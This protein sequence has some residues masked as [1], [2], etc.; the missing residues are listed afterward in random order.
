[1]TSQ[2]DLET[3]QQRVVRVFVS[4]TFRDMHAEREELVKRIFP[5]LRKLCEIRGVTWGEVD[6]RWGIPEE[7]KAEGKVLPICLAEIERCRPYFIGLL[8]ERYGWVPVDIPHDLIEQEPWLAEHR[9]RSV[10]ELEILHGVLN[11]PSMTG[12]SFFYFRDPAYID[13]LPADMQKEFREGPT[14]EEIRRLG[15]D[16]AE[17]RTEERRQKLIALKEQ[18]RSSGLPVR[19][20]YQN[21]QQLGQLVSQDMIEVI[22]QLYP[23]EDTPDPLK[24]EIAEHEAFARSR[25]RVYIGRQEYFNRLDEHVSSDGPPLVVLG[26]SGVGKSALLANWAIRYRPLHPDELFALH[27]IGA[28]PYSANWSAMLRH[29]MSELSRLFGIEQAIP[30]EPAELR[31]VFAN[32]LHMVAAQGRVVLILDALNQLEDRDQAPDL[33]WLPTEIPDNIRLILSTLPSRSLDNLRK[34][35]WPALTVKPLIVEERKKLIPEYLA[36]YT[37]FKINGGF[38]CYVFYTLAPSH[39]FIAV[40]AD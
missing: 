11:N 29:I 2:P 28:N 31:Q 38:T 9:D 20:N 14:S 35:G 15:L 25:A 33:V 10:T 37:A 4:S 40:F 32:W 34:R 27:F 3:S 17:W 21:P 12:H 1:M 7:Q 13:S 5:Q 24:R 18:V 23:E 39:N 16:E 19:E 22:D 36:Q 26:E 6:L 8:G 30:E